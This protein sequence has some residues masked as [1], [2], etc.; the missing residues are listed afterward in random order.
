MPALAKQLPDRAALRY[1]TQPNVL[2][3]SRGVTQWSVGERTTVLAHTDLK[4]IRRHIYHVLE[5]EDTP[6]LEVKER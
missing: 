1:P 4:A 5:L 6:T 3:L 2:I